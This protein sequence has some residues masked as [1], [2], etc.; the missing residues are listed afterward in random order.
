MELLVRPEVDGT[1]FGPAE[2]R[3][4]EKVASE[5]VEVGASLVVA[6]SFVFVE[7]EAELTPA[8]MQ[9]GSSSEGAGRV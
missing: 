6:A 8:L 1:V 7:A 9:P 3:V 5:L 2:R 4:D